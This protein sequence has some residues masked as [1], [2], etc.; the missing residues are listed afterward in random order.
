MGLAVMI[1]GPTL[2]TT[3]WLWLVDNFLMGKGVCK[4]FSDLFGMICC[5]SKRGK[6]NADNQYSKLPVKGPDGSRHN[7]PGSI[8]RT[9]RRNRDQHNSKDSDALSDQTAS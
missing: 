9:S 6:E 4:A 5:R 7:A 3:L 2:L 8:G 1:V